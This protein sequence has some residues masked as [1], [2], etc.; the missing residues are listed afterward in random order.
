MENSETKNDFKISWQMFKTNYKAF[1]ATEIFAILAFLVINGIILGII[2]S[3]FAISPNLTPSDLIPSA[4]SDFK[5]TF[6]VWGF[7]AAL[8]YLII[9]GFL[10]C[11]FGL[12]YDIFS[13]GDMFTEFK[14]A[15]V[16][17]KT[18]WWKYILLTFVTGFGF[19]APDKRMSKHDPTPIEANY[20]IFFVVSTILRFVALFFIVIVF[21]ST[22][23]SVTAQR[24]LKNGFIESF[25]IV[26]KNFKRL[27]KTWGLYFLLF[28]VPVLVVTLTLVLLLPT[29]QGT[30]V[31]PIL[32]AILAIVYI[33]RLFIGF[34]MMALISTRI[35]NTA[36]F[37]RFKPLPKAK[38]K[39]VETETD[40][41]LK[42]K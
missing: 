20:E 39:S 32:I 22:L 23:P 4:S 41:S 3:I 12:A 13:S 21:N 17:F 6:R 24:S 36:D 33:Y 19:F 15:F 2:V 27:F 11:Q 40:D 9:S 14:K 38:S 26:R 5:L 42:E 25:R 31:L 35:Y 16:Y 18:N 30:V 8:S 7:L 1:I 37:E 34:P 29:I 28:S 10:F